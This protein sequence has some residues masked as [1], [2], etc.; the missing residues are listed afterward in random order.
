MTTA[1]TERNTLLFLS[2]SLGC[3]DNSVMG[4]TPSDTY[5]QAELRLMAK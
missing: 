1:K 5:Q 3:L 2:E 4:W